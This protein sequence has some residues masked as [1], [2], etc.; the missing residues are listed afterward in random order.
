MEVIGDD[1]ELYRRLMAYYV[2]PDGSVSSAAFRDGSKPDPHCSV[3][4]A[5]LTTPEEVLSLGLPG[6]R[7]AS[8][9]AKIPRDL[10]LEVEHDGIGHPAHCVIKGMSRQEECRLLARGCRLV[11]PGGA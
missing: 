7:V 11:S 10:G 1:D 6:Q 3:Y 4:L 9:P 2:K 8:L 5:R